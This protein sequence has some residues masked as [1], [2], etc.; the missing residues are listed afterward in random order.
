[1]FDS[2]ICIFKDK[3]LIGYTKSILLA[4]SICEKYPNLKWDIIAELP[5]GFLFN[6]PEF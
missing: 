1:M 4:N 6:L 2:P 3:K 5:L